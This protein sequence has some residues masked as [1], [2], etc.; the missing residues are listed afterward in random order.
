MQKLEKLERGS[1]RREEEE[2]GVTKMGQNAKIFREKDRN[3]H[4]IAKNVKTGEEERR[5]A[6][7]ARCG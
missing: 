5:G 2:R 4:Q 1:R 7:G 6:G 3:T